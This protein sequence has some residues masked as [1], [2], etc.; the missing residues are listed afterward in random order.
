LRAPEPQHILR[1]GRTIWWSSVAIALLVAAHDP[2]HAQKRRHSSRRRARSPIS[3][4]SDQEKSL[5][6]PLLSKIRAAAMPSFRPLPAGPTLPGL[7]PPV[8]AQ[9][10]L[11]EFRKAVADCEKA[12]EYG[13][14][15]LEMSEQGRLLQG[16]GDSIPDE[17][18]IPRNRWR[19]RSKDPRS[20]REGG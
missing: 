13:Q 14:G 6:P 4:Y 15:S 2:I 17:G 5:I 20:E 19:S 8:Q 12:V 18:A 16:F 10:M 7:L 3:R 9:G 11:G 1:S